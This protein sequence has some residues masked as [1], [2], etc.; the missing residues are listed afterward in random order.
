[1]LLYI[2]YFYILYTSIYYIFLY[3]YMYCCLTYHH[4]QAFHQEE[5]YLLFDLY[6]NK[7][8]SKDPEVPLGVLHKQVL[9]SFAQVALIG[10]FLLTCMQEVREVREERGK[11]RGR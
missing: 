8:P 6:Q 4:S 2:I 3:I 1:M 7:A 11:E 5:R 9:P 10:A